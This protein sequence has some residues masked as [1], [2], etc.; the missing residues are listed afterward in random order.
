MRKSRQSYERMA[1]IYFSQ[2]ERIPQGK[3]DIGVKM[4]NIIN[5]DE[6]AKIIIGGDIQNIRSQYIIDAWK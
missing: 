3:G 6:K 2:I 4:W 5:Y 1:K